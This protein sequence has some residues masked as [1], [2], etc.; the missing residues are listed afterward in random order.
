MEKLNAELEDR[1]VRILYVYTREPHAR[2][3]FMGFDFSDE[4]ETR[5]MK[6]RMENAR[7]CRKKY[8]FGIR[9]IID[10]MKGSIQR[11][12]GGLPNS[13]F[14]IRSDGVVAY[15]EAW[16]DAGNLMSEV[17]KLY[18]P[19]YYVATPEER[20][21]LR[22]IYEKAMLLRR[23]RK[24]ASRIRAAEDL[25]RIRHPAVLARLAEGL[26]DRESSVRILCWDLL[27]GLVDTTRRFNPGDSGI[28][29]AA[30]AE[31]LIAD[32][33]K[34]GRSHRWNEKSGRFVPKKPEEEKKPEEKEKKD[35]GDF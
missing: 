6:E 9:W 16:A 14:V 12:Y 22:N 15:K 4:P 25:S 1:D 18:P 27:R 2:Q 10:D 30:A 7:R 13:G 20:K 31:A 26:K 11:S 23:A 32:L 24:T 34:A 35:S 8:K 3:R 28:A 33:K 21:T 5:S 29:R 19:A 17:R